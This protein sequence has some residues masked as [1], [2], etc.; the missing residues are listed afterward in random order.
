ML[1]ELINQGQPGKQT[2]RSFGRYKSLEDAISKVQNANVEIF[3]SFHFNFGEIH[4]TSVPDLQGVSKHLCPRKAIKFLWISFKQKEARIER[5]I[6]APK[7]RQMRL[8]LKSQETRVSV[9]ELTKPTK[10]N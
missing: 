9:K 10:P 7:F 4:V 6:L 2:S 1:L 3:L 8:P 5:P